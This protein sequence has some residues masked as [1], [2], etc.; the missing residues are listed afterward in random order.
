MSTTTVR[1]P[2]GPS[3]AQPAE[4]RTRVQGG[5]LDPALLVRSLPDALA[6][7]NPA[8]LWRNPVMF[9]V[10][11]GAA[12]ATFLAVRDTSAFSWLIVG[13][14][15]LTVLF[16]NL[17]EAV[18]EGRGKAQAETLRRAKQD[19][20]ARRLVGNARGAV[21]AVAAAALFNSMVLLS[22]QARLRLLDLRKELTAI[23]FLLAGLTGGW[24]VAASLRMLP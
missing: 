18:A 9:I 3:A 24:A 13:W 20:I 14:L 5:V 16:A 19:T 23:L 2:D 1:E 15:W 8:T 7:L 6:K 17:A 22:V 21:I 12:W 10:E 4:Q 11:I